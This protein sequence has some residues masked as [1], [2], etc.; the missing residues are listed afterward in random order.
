MYKIGGTIALIWL[1]VCVFL[2]VSAEGME[3]LLP[4]SLLLVGGF[5]L[6]TYFLIALGIKAKNKMVKIFF[7]SLAG[8]WLAVPIISKAFDT[9]ERQ[10]VE[11]KQAETVPTQTL[12]EE[13]FSHYNNEFLQ[14]KKVTYSDGDLLIQI[15]IVEDNL[16]KGFMKFE[17]EVKNHLQSSNQEANL[18]KKFFENAREDFFSKELFTVHSVHFDIWS[19]TSMPDKITTELYYKSKILQSIST[20][21]YADSPNPHSLEKAK[22]LFDELYDIKSSTEG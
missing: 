15:D 19:R 2:F 14:L 3:V 1:A 22:E 13:E 18:E 16:K 21:G 11:E 6:V 20:R 12:V 17:E 5:I 10:Q 8:L 7:F 4:F 9:W